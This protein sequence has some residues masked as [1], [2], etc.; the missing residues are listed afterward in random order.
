MQM[1][2]DEPVSLAKILDI[3]IKLY[4]A[5]FT[6]W[7]GFSTVLGVLSL[8]FNW[9]IKQ[10]IGSGADASALAERGGGAFACY[11]GCD[12]VFFCELCRDCLSLGQ[13][14]PSASR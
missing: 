8:G 2:A 4:V 5:S 13:Y 9:F 11:S 14:G 3:S 1:L 12:T 6:K 10:Y 7:I